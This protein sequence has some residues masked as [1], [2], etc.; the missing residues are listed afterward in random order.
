MK[1]FVVYA[2][3]PHLMRDDITWDREMTWTLRIP[4]MLEDAKIKD[5]KYKTAYCCSPD[6]KMIV[7]FEGPDK[8]TVSDALKRISLAFTTIMETTKISMEK[9]TFIVHT[10]VPVGNIDVPAWVTG[11][12][13]ML[14]NAN[15]EDISLRTAYCCTPEKKVIAEFQ[16]PDEG[17]LKRILEKI[18]IPFTAIIESTKV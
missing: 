7:E 6:M 2:E 3:R 5:V 14:S 12:P 8:N 10:D 4:K 18:G 9:K 13:K 15:V 17:T 1:T 11:I 16:A